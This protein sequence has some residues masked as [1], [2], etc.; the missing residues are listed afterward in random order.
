MASKRWFRIRVGVLLAVLVGVVLW[1]VHDQR[2]RRGRNDWDHTLEIALVLVEAAPVPPDAVDAVRAR[3]PALEERLTSE[4]RRRRADAPRPFRFVVK[5]S[6]AATSP[7][8]T[9]ASDG[10]IDLAKHAYA[11]GAWARDVDARAG[12]D[13]SA[14]DSRVYLVVRPPASAERQ[15][16]EGESEQGG[17]IGT[18][19]VELDAS[20]ADFVLFV[21]AHELFHTLGASDAYDATGLARVPEGLPE[22]ERQPLYP[23]RFAEV[24]ARNLVLAPGDERPPESLDEL[25]VGPTTA[26][27]IGWTS[28]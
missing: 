7:V 1:A 19:A 27:A 16:V 11:L 20:M 2:S 25:A 28:Q 5:G 4:L 24:M 9:A 10:V 26:H 22:P 3:V 8:P 6:V 17:R 15:E 12:V 14:Y 13:A 18:V 23:Q 21:A